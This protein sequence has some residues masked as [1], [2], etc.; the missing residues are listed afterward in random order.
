MTDVYHVFIKDRRFHIGVSNRTGS[1]FFGLLHNHL[2]GNIVV[3]NILGKGLRDF[4]IL[5]KLTLEIAPHCCQ[6]KRGGSRKNMKEGFLLNR[7]QM[8]CAGVSVDQAI[9]FSISIFT[10]STKTPLSFGNTASFWAKFA[11]DLSSIQRSKI[12]RELC[13]D[14]ALLGYLCPRGLWEAEEMSCG[15]HTKTCSTKLQK[16]PLCQVRSRNPLRRLRGSHVG[17]NEMI[18]ERL[19]H[20]IGL[21]LNLQ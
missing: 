16:P 3:I 19:A 5:T 11:L 20:S 2:R 13:L 14:E 17:H 18:F 21:I 12:R 7:I 8:N 6:G 15:E 1:H 9:I 4:P 10:N